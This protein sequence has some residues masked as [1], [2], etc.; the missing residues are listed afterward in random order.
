MRRLKVCEQCGV[1][2]AYHDTR[3]PNPHF[4]SRACRSA[5]TAAKDRSGLFDAK[6][7]KTDNGCWNW[8]AAADKHGYGRFGVPGDKL[9]LAH[10]FSY[11]RVHGPVPEGLELDH[12]C[13]NPRC[14]N[15]EH[16][17]AVTHQENMRRGAMTNKGVCRKA[18]HPMT[19][20]NTTSW[21][22]C[23]TCI[24]ERNKKNSVRRNE[25]QR[26]RRAKACNAA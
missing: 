2:F 23:K 5:N 19:P 6:F 24:T 3:W 10:V 9:V 7:E 13:R 21:G 16:L 25:L 11:E 14:V 1:E 26:I 12:L 4:C 20:E 8:T 17:E 15:P 22:A 18:G